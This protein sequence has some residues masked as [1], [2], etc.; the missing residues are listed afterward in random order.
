M[1]QVEGLDVLDYINRPLVLPQ[2]VLGCE[3]SLPED[4]ATQK[5]LA[6][7]LKNLALPASSIQSLSPLAARISGREF[8]LEKNERGIASISFSFENDAC[9]VAVRGEKSTQRLT[10]GMGRWLTDGNEQDVA[11]S[12]FVLPE[13]VKLTSKVAA[14]ATWQDDQ[15]LLVN[16]KFI[17]N[18]HGDQWTCR[19]DGDKLSISFLNSV[20]VIRKEKEKRTALAGRMI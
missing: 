20:A 15:T 2:L 3:G 4:A 16:L 13:Q 6:E 11:V 14:S 7:D 18:V 19:F 10:C 12:L 8:L 1:L 9:Q 5:L 17:E